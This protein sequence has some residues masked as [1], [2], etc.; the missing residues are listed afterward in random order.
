LWLG[1]RERLREPDLR[2]R[3]TD[4]AIE[5]DGPNLSLL[6]VLDVA[7][8]MPD[9]EWRRHEHGGAEHTLFVP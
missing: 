3:L 7:I 8:R 4:I 1:L 9:M 5:S 2:D 6:R